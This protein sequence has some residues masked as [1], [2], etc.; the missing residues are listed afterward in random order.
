M[1]G[2]AKPREEST[3]LVLREGCGE[4]EGGE[5]CEQLGASRRGRGL[6]MLLCFCYWRS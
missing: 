5:G 3:C 6:D 1:L 4:Q 2:L